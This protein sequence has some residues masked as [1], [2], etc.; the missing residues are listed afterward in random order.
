M[1]HVR[2]NADVPDPRGVLS[3]TRQCIPQHF[4]GTKEY[5][6]S[7]RAGKPGPKIHCREG[8]SRTARAS[9]RSLSSGANEAFVSSASSQKKRIWP[10]CSCLIAHFFGDAGGDASDSTQ[11]ARMSL[12]QVGRRHTYAVPPATSCSTIV[13]CMQNRRRKSRPRLL[14]TYLPTPRVGSGFGTGANPLCG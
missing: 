5:S 2:K 3:G 7:R 13:G 14:Q 6:T 8:L 1:V 4:S 12:T 9:W 11:E 10:P